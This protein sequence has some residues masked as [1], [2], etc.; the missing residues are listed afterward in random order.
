MISPA[1]PLTSALREFAGDGRGGIL[2]GLAPMLPMLLEQGAGQLR[3]LS[4]EEIDGALLVV[5][6]ACIAARSTDAEGVVICAIVAATEV[7]DFDAIG[8]VA[9]DVAGDVATHNLD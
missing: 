8:R 5:A 9:G 6:Q 2:A 3:G 7:E 4:A 1:S